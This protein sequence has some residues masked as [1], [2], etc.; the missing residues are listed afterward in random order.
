MKKVL[1]IVGLTLLLILF[2]TIMLYS[3]VSSWR[4]NPPQPR[5]E[6]PR[7]APSVPQ[8]NDV[9][10]WRSTPSQPDPRGRV[11]IQ[12]WGRANQ[13]GYYWGNWGWYQP[14]PYIWYDDFGW[15]QRSIIHVY[16]NGKRD[17]I[18]RESAYGS[19]GVGHTNNKQVSFWGVV[20]RKKGYFILDYTMSYDIDQNQYYPY[21]RINEVDFPLSNNDFIK[22]GTLYLGGGKRYRK[23]GVHGM[24]GFGNEV[25]RYQ[26]RDALGGI[27]FPKSNSNFTTF[28]FGI[29]RD[30]KFFT[31]RLD[32]DPIRNFNQISIGLHNK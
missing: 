6:V 18:R 22:Q 29:L 1:L 4:S 32:R 15:R 24:I 23:L 19:F 26:G 28:K 12:N 8:R 16:E 10:R 7:I 5:T 14:F 31:L 2:C 20:G 17:T 25:I 27:S 9:S 13:F 11:R 30:F 3:Q 21:G